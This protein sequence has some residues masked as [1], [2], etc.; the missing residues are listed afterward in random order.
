MTKL[1]RKD[2][3]WL[4]GLK[5]AKLFKALKRAFTLALVLVYYNYTKKIV[6]ETDVLNWV[7]NGVLS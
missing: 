3:G 4:W 6:V 1:L 5:Q 7:S 2:I